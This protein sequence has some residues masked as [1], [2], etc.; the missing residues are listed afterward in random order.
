VA[1]SEC[2]TLSLHDALPIVVGASHVVDDFV[3]GLAL[4]RLLTS[5]ERGLTILTP[6][7]EVLVTAGLVVLE[8]LPEVALV[9][10]RVRELDALLRSEEHTSELQ[11]RENLVCR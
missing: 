4:L 8:G 2:D 3:R 10:L 6:D 1:S 5:S 11:S 7:G 9:G